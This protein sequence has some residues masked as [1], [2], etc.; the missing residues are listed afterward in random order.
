MKQRVLYLVRLG[1]IYLKGANRGFFEKLLK[2]NIRRKLAEL[3]PTMRIQKGRFFIEADES[4][5]PQFIE[6]ALETT[7]GIVGFSRAVMT[8]KTYDVIS[9]QA[10]ELVKAHTGE[11]PVTF[12]VESRRADKSFEMDSYQ[13]SKQLG[14]DL[15]AAIGNLS[16]D[17]HSP[18]LTV[19]V[20]VRDKC[21]VYLSSTHNRGPGGLPVGAA[22]R[23]LLMLSGGIDSPVAGYLMANRGMRLEAVYFHTYPYTSDD[24]LEKVKSL[25]RTLSPYL[26]GVKLHIINFTESQLHIN[27]HAKEEEYTLLMRYAMV[28]I[29]NMIADQRHIQALVTG[30]SLSQVA[31]QTIESIAF[32]ESASR[33]PILRPLIGMNKESIISIASKIGTYETSILPY[34][35]CCT[36]FS[37]KHPIL[38]PDKR[39]MKETYDRMGIDELLESACNNRETMTL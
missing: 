24:A 10:I 11:E 14:S 29:S 28:R 31:S 18:E 2:R 7:M 16:V 17:V 12:K 22:G 27:S 30:E 39:F 34:D 38:R 4:E 3:N 13:I 20:E 37:A 15:L 6:H 21:Y 33:I 25:G 8:E 36:I 9:Q 35:D 1:E 26:N 23:G 19:F 5:Q 32:T